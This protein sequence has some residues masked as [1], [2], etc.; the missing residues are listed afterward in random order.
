MTCKKCGKEVFIGTIQVYPEYKPSMICRKCLK[1][2]GWKSMP[3]DLKGVINE[4]SRD[5]SIL[6][7]RGG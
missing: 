6:E 7:Y 3:F 4:R 5:F 2:M 1:E